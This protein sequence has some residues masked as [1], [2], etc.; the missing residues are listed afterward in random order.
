MIFLYGLENY[1]LSPFERILKGIQTHFNC[2]HAIMNSFIEENPDQLA[3]YPGQEVDIVP[4]LRR[5]AS[6]DARISHSHFRCLNS[7]R[8]FELFVSFDTAPDKP[9]EPRDIVVKQVSL[10]GVGFPDHTF[11]IVK[12]NNSL[13]I[14][15]SYYCAYS[16]SG[17]YGL[18]KL[19]ET[20]A[21]EFEYLLELYISNEEFPYRDVSDL[22]LE[23]SKY[24][25][26]NSFEH[27]LDMRE[28]TDYRYCSIISKPMSPEFFCQNM[29]NNI[30]SLY[31]YVYTNP[32]DIS[33]N[34]HYKLYLCFKDSG[35]ESLERLVGVSVQN[36]K[37]TMEQDSN[38][39][40]Y[41]YYS[42]EING[43]FKSEYCHEIL[44]D[45]QNKV[46][47]FVKEFQTPPR[48]IF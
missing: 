41:H 9:R 25:G 14:L 22:N 28:K 15:Q 26:V 33:V 21:D 32:K 30:Y 17:K 4:G 44:L 36:T 46:V 27:A 47:E 5:T 45:I 12:Y 37:I 40:I 10:G 48:F 2:I 31:R 24:T 42:L 8:F 34:I 29:L 16:M 3:C 43:V 39:K 11:I 38:F 1:M 35:I 6:V 7:R 20:E 13:Y 23:L 18:I 19:D